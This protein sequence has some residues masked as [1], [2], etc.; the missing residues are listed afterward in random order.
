MVE[1]RRKI[2]AMGRVRNGDQFVRDVPKHAAP[3]SP[4]APRGRQIALDGRPYGAAHALRAQHGE[5]I[6]A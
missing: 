6:G 4:A 3:G 5:L 1:E 2:V